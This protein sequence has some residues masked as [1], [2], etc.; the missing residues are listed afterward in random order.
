MIQSIVDIPV[1]DNNKY[2][3]QQLVKLPKGK[4]LM[5]QLDNATSARTARGVVWNY[6]KRH[7][8]HTKTHT[9]RENRHYNLYV[10]R[11]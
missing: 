6:C 4:A 8:L 11:L 3:L 1:L 9:E 2:D 10:W 5:I 7:E